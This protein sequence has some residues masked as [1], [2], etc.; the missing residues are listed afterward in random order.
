MTRMNQSNYNSGDLFL[1][2]RPRIKQLLAEAAK[3]PLVMIC[4]GAGYGKT[5]AVY[6]FVRESVAPIGWVPLNERDNIA[7]RFW[8]NYANSVSRVNPS[9]AKAIIDLGFP[10]TDDKLNRYF[11]IIRS[12]IKRKVRAQVFDDFHFI[13]DPAI[14]RVIERILNG[15]QPEASAFFIARSTSNLN[16]ANMVSKGLV[17]NIS[18][19]ELRFTESELTEY[20]KQQ[21]ISISLDE[22]RDIYE[23]T[24]GWA[25]AINLIARSYQ[26]APAY[27]GYLRDAMRTNIFR[28]MEA[29]SYS[30]VSE[31]LQNFFIRLSLIDHLSVELITL[32]AKGDVELIKEFETQNAY[33]R[34][35]GYTNACMIHHLFLEFLREKQGL[36]TDE[37][38]YETYKIAADWCNKNGFKIDALTYY[39]KMGNYE[40][41]VSAF[42]GLPTQVPYEIAS[43][44]A[45]IFKH[46]PPEAFDRVDL[47]AAMHV[48]SVMRLGLWKEA[49]ELVA[50]YEARF[51]RLP[52]DDLFR[53]HTLGGIYYYKGVLRALMCTMDDRYDF[54]IYYAKMAECLTKAPLNP[55]VLTNQPMGPWSSV[56]SSRRNAPQEFIDALARTEAHAS[57]CMNGA[58]TGATD[59]ARGALL[60][61]QSNIQAAEPLIVRG[62]E[63]SRKHRQFEAVHMALFFLLRIAAFQGNFKKADR[64]LKDMEDLLAETEFTERFIMYDIIRTWYLNYLGMPEQIPD[65]LKCGFSSYT[66]TYFIENFCNRMKALY[67][68]HTKN[69]S[70]LLAYIHEHRQRESLLFGRL[71]IRAMEACV[72]FKMKNKQEAF[73][74]LKETYDEASPNELFMPFI[75]MGK[76]MRTLC[77]TA[78]KEPKGGIPVSW[79]EMIKSKASSYA[80]RQSHIIAEYKKANN[81]EDDISLT[82]RETDVLIDLSHGLSRSEIAANRSLSVNTVKMVINSIYSKFGAENQANLIRIAVERKII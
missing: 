25:F 45:E 72:H 75:K 68:Y 1:F 59:L 62:L 27:K 81:I 52:K 34:F 24:D 47:L 5:S 66:H 56:G 15:L 8:E 74:V 4:A 67:C 46:A 21:N 36:L 40:A 38:K 23:D 51:L 11:S 69:Y 70:P 20:F 82:A 61:H 63:Q 6:D 26:K 32:L 77:S 9:Y 41:I 42:S 60:Y 43:Y 76:D 10:D 44:T 80:K 31:A 29:E 28:L 53:N 55:D 78:L 19:N 12:H 35:D 58:M 71:E 3:Y 22:L 50:G 13:K 57:G 49:L 39:E 54:D 65:W 37:E 14:M 2:E 64:S 79:L 33:V 17:Y 7:P 16:I 30:G 73:A 18:E 48:R